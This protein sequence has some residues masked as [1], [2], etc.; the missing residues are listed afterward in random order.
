MQERADVVDSLSEPAPQTLWEAMGMLSRVQDEQE[1]A[2]RQNDMERLNRLLDE[3]VA[4]WSYVKAF[5]IQ[6]IENGKAPED[7][8]ERLG[9]VL[10]VHKS[11]EEQLAQVRQQVQEEL[12][13]AQEAATAAHKYQQEAA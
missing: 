11:R 13:Q 7:L 10:K 3:Q 9:Q 1:F 6:L 8:I 12:Q 2:I 5:A 4:A